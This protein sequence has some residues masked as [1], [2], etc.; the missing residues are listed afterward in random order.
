VNIEFPAIQYL[1]MIEFLTTRI[2]KMRLKQPVSFSRTSKLV[3]LLLLSSVV[4]LFS[5]C[6]GADVNNSNAPVISGQPNTSLPMPPLNGKSLTNMGWSLADGK[7]SAFS[8]FNGKVLVLDFYATWCEP[9]RRSTPHLVNL[10]KRYE[11]DL[12]VIGL[13]VGGPE[14][15]AEV[16]TYAR[17][18]QIQYQLGVPDD[19]LVSLLL[20][21]SDAIPQT[22]VFDR[23]GKLVQNF[24]GF[25]ELTGDEIDKAVES[26]LTSKS[27]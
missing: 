26:A 22:F 3:G 14:D 13:N 1:R 4:T 15:V 8:D 11:N 7:R 5:G 24:V 27:D 19:E 23:N 25:G 20:S 9:C 6:N 17:E 16:P 21:G 18:F 10:Q 12:R 2:Q